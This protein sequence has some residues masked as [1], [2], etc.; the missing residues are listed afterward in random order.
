MTIG[1]N[2]KSLTAR[3]TRELENAQ[4]QRQ[5]SMEKLA[6]GKVF[7]VRDPKPAERALAENMEF[8][9]RSLAS[10][11]KNVNDAVSLLQTAESGLSEINNIIVRLK[12]LSVAGASTVLTDQERRYLFIEYEALRDEIDRIALTTEFN[13]IPLLNGASDRAPEQLVFRAGDPFEDESVGSFREDDINTIRFD[14]LKDVVATASGLGLQSA[15]DILADST[16]TAG[17]AIEDVVELL[18]P[19]EKGFATIYDEALNRLSTQ[20]AIFGAMQ[21]RLQATKNY[22]DV[23]QENLAAARSSIADTDYAREVVKLTESSILLQATSGLLAQTNFDSAVT[24]NLLK[25]ISG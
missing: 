8:K 10:S 13:G 24:I 14:G 4:N 16:G 18:E 3:L 15:A 17:I 5:D 11:K 7:T 22:I 6:A 1:L 2:N 20:R 21:S 19:Y 25:S 9:L 12:E 23:Y